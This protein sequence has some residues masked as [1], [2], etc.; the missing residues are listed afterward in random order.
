[1]NEEK[2]HLDEL[3]RFIKQQRDELRLR[4]HLAGKDAKDEY[5]R[6]EAKWKELEE[7][8]E[9]LAEAA[10]EAAR[11]AE[12]QAKSVASTALDTAARELKS[13]YEK[14]QAFLRE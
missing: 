10:K 12:A 8:A 3:Y 7:K 5:A 2:D 4:M 14:L 11:D 6:L 9:P 1:M 13:G